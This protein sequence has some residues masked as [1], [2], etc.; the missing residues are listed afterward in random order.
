MHHE[1]L[2]VDTSL[3]EDKKTDAFLNEVHKKKVSNE[4]RQCNREKKLQAQE[5]LPIG[6]QRDQRSQILDLITQPCNSTSLEAFRW[7]GSTS[8]REDR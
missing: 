5:S 8:K 4:I 2:L 6:S 3:P 7:R 1:K